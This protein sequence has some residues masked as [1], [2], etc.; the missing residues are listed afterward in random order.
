MEELLSKFK[1]LSIKYN[2][3]CFKVLEG[4][5]FVVGIVS[6][7]GPIIYKFDIKY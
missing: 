3:L 1:E 7:D 6:N 2:N 5:F 4:D